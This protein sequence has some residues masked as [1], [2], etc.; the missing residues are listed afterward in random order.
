VNKKI[1]CCR[2][3]NNREHDR[4]GRKENENWR[5]S[6]TAQYLLELRELVIVASITN[7]VTV[8]VGND[9]GLSPDLTVNK[10]S[11]GLYVKRDPN[12]CTKNVDQENQ[13]KGNFRQ[14]SHCCAKFV[15]KMT[16]AYLFQGSH[17]W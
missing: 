1:I 3:W 11:Q 16:E 10:I 14:S 12:R 7:P 17:F 2:N 9:S 4:H 8:V 6:H 5:D 13:K 15:S